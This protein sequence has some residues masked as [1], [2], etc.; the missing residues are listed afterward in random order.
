MVHHP[1]LLEQVR[2]DLGVEVSPQPERFDEHA[3]VPRVGLGDIEVGLG[4]TAR[5]ILVSGRESLD[6]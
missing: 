3:H 6:D 1:D 5:A 4:A 2:T